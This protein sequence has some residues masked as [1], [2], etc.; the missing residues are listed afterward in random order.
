[1]CIRDR[2]KIS[3]ACVQETKWVG[4]KAREVDGY[5]LWYS[6]SSKARN[7]VGILVDKELVSFVV[8]VRRKSDRITAIKA[9]VGSKIL[10]VVSVYAPQIGLPNYI[11]KQFWEDFDMVILDV[12][13]SKKLFVGGDF[14]S[15]IGVEVDEYDAA[16]G[17]FGYGKRNNGGVSVLDF[18]IAYDLL[19]ANSFFKKK[20]NHL[21]TFR[22]GP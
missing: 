9:V 20:E 3:I 6:G 18:A 10:N 8:E 5:K 7:G 14:N 22:S 4:A 15:H 1:M 21:V 2:H 12:P 13:R 16:H 17:G 11:K 19:V